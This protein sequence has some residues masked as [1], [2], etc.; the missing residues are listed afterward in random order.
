MGPSARL[1]ADDCQALA[2]AM[3]RPRRRGRSGKYAGGMFICALSQ[4]NEQER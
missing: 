4:V 1:L 3:I 2:V